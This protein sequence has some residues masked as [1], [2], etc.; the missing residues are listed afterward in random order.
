MLKNLFYFLLIIFL[1]NTTLNAYTTKFITDEQ[2]KKVELL[3][4]KKGKNRLLLFD[5]MLL[6]AKNKTTLF[7]L[8]IVNDFFN[9]ITYKSDIN[10]WKEK[11]Y[12]ATPFE[13][14]GSGAGDCEDFAIAK[15]FALRLLGVET[16]KLKIKIGY[17][18]GKQIKK[19]FI[20]HAVLS[21][22]SNSQCSPIILDNINK[23]LISEKKRKDLTLCGIIDVTNIITLQRLIWT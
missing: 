5:K 3:Y 7:K 14:I 16:S 22:H 15:Y 9:K 2:L 17:V 8:Q 12:L 1:F 20:K 19:D 6:K 23:N 4:G 10:H 21:Y 13:F 18:Q 11:E